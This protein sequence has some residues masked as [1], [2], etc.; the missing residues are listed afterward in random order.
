MHE[1]VV[2]VSPCLDIFS[3]NLLRF[4]MYEI[5]SLFILII[6]HNLYELILLSIARNTINALTW[7]H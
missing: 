7:T 2:G 5:R 3:P 4:I 6:I 1:K